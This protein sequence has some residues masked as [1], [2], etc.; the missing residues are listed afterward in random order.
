MI[1][2]IFENSFNF[3]DKKEFGRIVERIADKSKKAFF[4]VDFVNNGFL[5]RVQAMVDAADIYRSENIHV[6]VQKVEIKAED[7][8]RNNNRK[9]RRTR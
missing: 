7:K 5:F 9:G 8:R 6:S 3:I 2:N 4:S 1:L